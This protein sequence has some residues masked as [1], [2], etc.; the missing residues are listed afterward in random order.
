M[1]ILRHTHPVSRVTLAL[2][3]LLWMAISGT[4]RAPALAGETPEG[5]PPKPTA[6]MTRSARSGPWSAAATWEGGRVPGA[7]AR[8][9]VRQGHTVV[10]DVRSERPIRSIHV[11]G[12]LTFARDKD[13]RLDVGLIKIQSGEDASEDGFDCDAHLPGASADGS[14]PALEVGT[15]GRPIGAEHTAV[16]RLVDFEGVD[17]GSWPAIVCCGGRMDFHGAPLSRTWVKLGGT[18]RVGG[19]TIILAEPVRG[20]RTGDRVIV[21]ATKLRRSGEYRLSNVETEERIIKGIGGTTLELDRPLGFPHEAIGDFRGEVANL[22]RNVVVESAEPDK[23]RGHT[24]YHRGSAGSISYAEFRHL[25]KEGVLGRYSLHYHRVGDTMRGSSVIGASIWDSANRWLTIHG[26]N[27]LV[28][29]DCVGYRS[30]GHGFFLED[31]TEVN[32]VLDRNLAVQALRGKMLPGQALPFDKNEGAGFWWANSLNTFTRNVACENERYGYRFEATPTGRVDLEMS[33]LQPDGVRRKVDIRTLPFVRFDDN[34]CHSDGLYGFNLG[35][36]V[37]RVG[38]DERHPFIVRRMK[39]WGTH[40]AIRLQ[41]PSVLLEDLHIH[42]CRY[43]MYFPNHDRHVYRHVTISETP[44]EPWSSGHSDDSVQYG[45]VTVDGLVF[46]NIRPTYG[47]LIALTHYNAS[48]SAASHFRNVEVRNWSG[49]EKWALANMYGG[50]ALLPPTP[51]G[52][53]IYLHDY[54]GP[55]RHAKVVSARAA[56]LLAD[57]N[58][59]REAPPLTGDESRVA[60][61]RDVAFPKLLDPVD[62]RPPV[63]VITCVLPSGPGK[64][65]VRGT[66]SDDGAVKRV[67]VNGREAVATDN[68]FTQWE[69]VLDGMLSDGMRLTASAEDAAGNLEKLP[70]TRGIED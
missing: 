6:E 30:I 50:K 67:V 24:M 13:T 44:D 27:Y 43:G 28:V 5:A 41:S 38:P 7:F 16:I 3:G 31:G 23:V 40:Y 9:Q 51:K 63:T 46:E 12:T 65:L 2:H 4:A 58:S 10:Y 19:T 69:A 64:L 62:D 25:G 1:N 20:W 47:I 39:I 17:K 35:E 68:H 66:T 22:S 49:S 14:R 42:K 26:T 60:E 8:V 15:P 70:H 33:V 48:G 52:V 18:A 34:E 29:R 11:A 61:V 32:N 53:P 57:G 45:V 55:N 59:Y 37:D 36:G 21:T 54:F 56:D